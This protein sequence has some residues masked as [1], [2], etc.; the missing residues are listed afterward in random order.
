MASSENRPSIAGQQTGGESL[1]GLLGRVG[2]DLATLL[3]AKL[4]LLKLEVEED[5]RAYA[6]GGVA[7]GLGSVVAAVGFGLFNIGIAFIMSVLIADSQLSQPMK[8]ALGFMITGA[9]D[10]IL[11]G[12]VIVVNKNRLAGRGIVP[13]KTIE[14]LQKDKRWLKREL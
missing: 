4:G 9:I 7:I 6:R 13:E 11:G 8:Y 12:G 3:D 14:E 2:E 5:M 10:L 1:P